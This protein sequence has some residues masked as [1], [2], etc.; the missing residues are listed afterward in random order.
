MTLIFGHPDVED[1][2]LD[3]VTFRLVDSLLPI[4]L[5]GFQMSEFV[6]DVDLDDLCLITFSSH[7]LSQISV[8]MNQEK[9]KEEFVGISSDLL[10]VSKRLSKQ[11]S[12]EKKSVKVLKAEPSLRKRDKYA[13]TLFLLLDPEF[14]TMKELLQLHHTKEVRRRVDLAG[15]FVIL[16]L[17][18]CINRIAFPF[19][20]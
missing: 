12:S 18:H 2:R 3:P 19:S 7:F 13:S 14:Q 9:G 4:H 11:I 20:M 15:S 10:C 5:I 8:R 6:T 1:N 16:V 17:V